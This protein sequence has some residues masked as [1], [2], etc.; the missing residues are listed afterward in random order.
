MPD[1]RLSAG[2]IMMPCALILKGLQACDS[3]LQRLQASIL[4]CKN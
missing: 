3:D 2:A 4:A 1:G